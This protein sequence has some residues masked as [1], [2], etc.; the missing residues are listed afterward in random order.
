MS[1]KGKQPEPEPVPEPEEEEVIE[2]GTGE[3]VFSS[4]AKYVGGWKSVDG[5]KVRDGEGVYSYGPEEYS[6]QWV[7][8]CMEGQG[9]HKFSSGACYE[10]EFKQNMFEG[11]GTYRFA[12][13][14]TYRYQSLC[15]L[16]C[17]IV[18][19]SNCYKL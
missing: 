15:M 9:T 16:G 4:G 1:K 11:T 3:F 2:T 8:D 19:I 5:V 13:G 6:G 14:A 18:I 10:G 12:D 17:K 7:D